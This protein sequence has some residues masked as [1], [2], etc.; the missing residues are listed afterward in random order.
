M[1]KD[2]AEIDIACQILR[3]TGEGM[4][5]KD[6][7]AKV[8]EIKPKRSVSMGQAMAEIHTQINMDS[9]FVYLGNGRW[10]LNQW[11]PRLAKQD[12][13]DLEELEEYDEEYDEEVDEEASDSDDDLLL[14]DR[15]EA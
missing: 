4:Y 13:S 10:G 15:E 11:G 2:I 7:I 12:E 5:F 8:L 3:E 1:N 6:L 9:R 14:R